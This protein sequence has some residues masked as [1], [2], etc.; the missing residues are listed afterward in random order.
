[1]YF[2]NL[3]EVKT[4]KKESQKMIITL[5]SMTYLPLLSQLQIKRSVYCFDRIILLPPTTFSDDAVDIRNFLPLSVAT[6][7]LLSFRVRLKEHDVQFQKI[8]KE[9][10]MK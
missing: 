5:S 7:S 2:I 3:N 8:K 4:L 10:N 1:M 9:L 6:S